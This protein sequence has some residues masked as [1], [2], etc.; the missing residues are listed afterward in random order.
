MN[1]PDLTNLIY[2]QKSNDDRI[3]IMP[4]RLQTTHDDS[5]FPMSRFVLRQAW[6]TTYNRQLGYTRSAITPFRAVTNAGDLLSR[7]N[8]SCGGNS[9][10][11]QSKPGMHGIK[12]RMG[13]VMNNCDNS[14]VPAASCNVKYV[15]DSS[16][17]TR[18]RKEREMN[19]NY[20][21]L[22]FGGN[23]DEQPPISEYYAFYNESLQ[24]LYY[25]TNGLSPEDMNPTRSIENDRSLL[26][27]FGISDDD[28]MQFMERPVSVDTG[29]PDPYTN[30]SPAEKKRIEQLKLLDTEYMTNEAAQEYM[31]PFG[32]TLD[33]KFTTKETKVYS[34]KYPARDNTERYYEEITVVHRGSCEL[35][36]VWTDFYAIFLG[37]KFL[38]PRFDRA[39]TIITD[40]QSAYGPIQINSVGHSLGGSLAQYSSPGGDVRTY[41]KGSGLLA[42]LDRTEPGQE[43]Y[44]TTCDLVSVLSYTEI[45]RGEGSKRIIIPKSV[46]TKVTPLYPLNYILDSHVIENMQGYV[47]MQQV[48][49]GSGFIG[50]PIPPPR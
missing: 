23:G 34:K 2:S 13:H 8:Y 15:Y 38:S 40:L 5:S 21:D 12:M 3:G 20:N 11:P 37:L 1:T 16:N 35:G 32:Y 48:G 10:T 30:A 43:D 27:S 22:T 4:P 24:Q 28:S 19:V 9:Q 36:D 45:L 31:A 44:R 25:E 49:Q 18:F 41:D 26:R 7:K 47:K 6:N 17:Y 29:R 50:P 14:S 46:E 42:F 33:T 39:K